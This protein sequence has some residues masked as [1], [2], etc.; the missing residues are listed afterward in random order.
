MTN[1]NK[2]KILLTGARAFCAMD[3]ARQ[4][5]AQGHEVYAADTSS[6]QLI[7]FSNA[8]VKY[9]TV[10]SPRTNAQAFVDD[11]LQIVDNEKIDL[12][13]P[14]WE[15]VM[16]L[17]PHAKKF[18]EKCTFFSSDF[19]TL[20]NLHNK[21]L[22]SQMLEDRGI[23][24]PKTFLIRTEEDLQHIDL[25]YP[26]ILKTCYSRASQNFMIATSSKDLHSMIKLKQPFVAQQFINGEKFCS[27][28]V[29]QK[30]KVVAH[31][32]Y[33]VGVTLEGSSCLVFESVHHDE[34][35][36]WTKQFVENLRYTGQIAFDFIIDGK[37]DIYPIEC[38]PRGT[39]G[40][41]LFKK[42]DRIDRAFLDLADRPILPQE[43]NQQ[44]I[45]LAMATLGWKQAFVERKLFSFLRK[46]VSTKDII[47][48]WSDLSP[49]LIQPVIY[50][51][52]IMES[53]RLGQSLAASFT[54][55]LD[56]NEG[57]TSTIDLEA[58]VQDLL[59]STYTPEILI[60][61]VEAEKV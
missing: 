2:Q 10:S 18:S 58:A 8:I 55:D 60:P 51:I 38:N 50:F 48:R 57:A 22:F 28:T 6:W 49:F 25:N 35:Y 37:G 29:C 19:K 36:E 7:K 9:F 56:W 15:E 44:Q 61:Q 41:H 39:S 11:I 13:I 31:A 14:A 34:I 17:A 42:E 43:G 4:L 5:N 40:L 24:S 47:F 53:R 21:W 32:C 30:G 26:F 46:L 45:V 54:F 23:L 59:D 12:L 16:Y 27:Y 33:P 20:Q 52:W 1:K 3:L